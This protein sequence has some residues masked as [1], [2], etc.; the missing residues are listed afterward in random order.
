MG[1]LAIRNMQTINA[2][3][4]EIATDWLPSI[5]TLGEL[6][7]GVISYRNVV[8]QHMLA[9][10][11]PEKLALEKALAEVVESNNKIRQTYEPMTSP[12]EERSLYNEWSKYW[13]EYKSGATEVL[14]LS[15]KAIGQTSREAEALNAGRL[16]KISSE[17]DAI[18]KK[19][20]DL[21]NTGAA[22]ETKRSADTYNSALILMA[23]V[24]AWQSR[25]ELVPDSIWF[26]T[27][28]AASRRS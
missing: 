3:T 17:A 18:L 19:D 9:E 25:L 22:T 2:N 1:L 11:L 26:T 27:F 6:R 16:H 13:D 4:V 24:S 21:N 5:R 14:A 12:L 20:I 28:H 23:I 7:Y 15:R 10:T 8:R